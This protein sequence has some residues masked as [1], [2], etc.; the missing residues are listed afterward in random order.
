MSRRWTVVCALLTY[1]GLI[2]T[3]T[4]LS[5]SPMAALAVVIVL[6]FLGGS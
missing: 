5:G 1:A 4:W 2:V 6:G 3:A